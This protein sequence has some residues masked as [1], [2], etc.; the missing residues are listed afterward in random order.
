MN[1]G[2]AYCF[3]DQYGSIIERNELF[4]NIISKDNNNI[5]DCLNFKDLSWESTMKYSHFLCDI[6]NGKNVNDFINN[7]F[8]KSRIQNDQYG[9][10]YF[11]ITD[12]IEGKGIY[13]IVLSKDRK[14]I[15]N[16]F[17]NESQLSQKLKQMTNNLEL[18]IAVIDDSITSCKM[19]QNV[20]KK[21]QIE[22]DVFTEAKQILKEYNI[23]I[24]DIYMP[25]ING[26]DFCSSYKANMN[27]SNCKIIAISGDMSET[28]ISEVM[29]AGF[30]GFL[31]KPIT[32][33]KIQAMMI[34]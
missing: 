18:K 24:V 15:N 5:I 10:L 31:P 17:S 33:D 12:Y 1:T 4:A 9:E 8:I 14:Q 16:I 7:K 2:E 29:R 13:G 22:C 27:T 20:F 32:F 30:D 11:V 28:L 34:N 26:L 6:Y 19:I 23:I 21:H 25:G 3:I